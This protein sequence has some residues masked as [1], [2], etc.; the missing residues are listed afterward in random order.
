MTPRI[1]VAATKPVRSVAAPPAQ[2][3]DRVAASQ[4]DPA[5]HVPAEA[6]D[7]KILAVLGIGDLDTVGVDSLLRQRSPYGLRGLCQ[8]RLM[9]DRDSA[10]AVE[11][12]NEIT[13][14]AAADH[15]R[16]RTCGLHLYTYGFGHCSTTPLR[17]FICL[18][19]STPVARRH[20]PDFGRR[21][22]S[23]SWPNAGTADDD[24]SST[25]GT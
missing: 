8:R 23:E 13:E 20:A 14:Q 21:S 16:V 19:V 12:G 25:P 24:A 11:L 2:T 18:E 15:D 17:L 7:S 6:R 1:H 5:E 4:A 10:R 3:H 22:E 9:E